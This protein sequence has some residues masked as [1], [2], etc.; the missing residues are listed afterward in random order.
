[1]NEFNDDVEVDNSV[2]PKTFLWMFLGL[3]SSGIVS[4][5]IYSSGLYMDIIFN[6][7]FNILLIF[8][9]VVVLLFTF[10]FRK[11]PA[12]AV[13]IMYFLYSALNGVTLSTIFVMFELN[14]VILLFI[15]SALLFGGFAFYGYMTSKDLSNWKTL[16]FGTLIA[17]LILSLLNLFF[18]NSILDIILGWVILFIFFGITAYDINKIKQLSLVDTL[19]QSKIHIYGAMQ[20]Y[21]DFVNIFLR[22]LAIF[23]KRKD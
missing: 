15:V 3:L 13:G 17:G 1:M 22:I 8:E 11:L 9:L 23:G 4:W 6:G 5:Y 10:L 12:T 19:N 18:N 16:L 7:Y 20:L 21:L 14:S 2:L